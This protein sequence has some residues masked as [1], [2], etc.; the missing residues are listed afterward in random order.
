MAASVTR[1]EFT[2][3]GLILSVIAVQF[4]INGVVDIYRNLP[5]GTV[6]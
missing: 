2:L 3:F 5:H 1:A 6:T 4:V